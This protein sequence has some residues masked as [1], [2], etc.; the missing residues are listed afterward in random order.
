MYRA[1]VDSPVS[2]L[3]RHTPTDVSQSR[4]VASSEAEPNPERSARAET[5]PRP[6]AAEPAPQAETVLAEGPDVP[7]RRVADLFTALPK[8]ASPDPRLTAELSRRN[9]GGP[10]SAAPPRLRARGAGRPDGIGAP[11]PAE[12][13]AAGKSGAHVEE[14][15]PAAGESAAHAALSLP[16]DGERAADA[17]SS[18]AAAGER[19]PNTAVSEPAAGESPAEAAAIFGRAVPAPA[20]PAL[21]KPRP[22]N[23]V[24]VAP[25]AAHTRAH[26]PEKLA[27]KLRAEGWIVSDIRP[28]DELAT[29]DVVLRYSD[30]GSSHA[31][32][33]KADIDRALGLVRDGDVELQVGGVDPGTLEVW[34]PASSETRKPPSAVRATAPADPP[35]ARARQREGAKPQPS[36]RTARASVQPAPVQPSPSAKPDRRA[37]PPPS[38]GGLPLPPE[39][40]PSSSAPP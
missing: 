35:K 28:V 26:E 32:E 2:V 37:A 4:P 1:W 8:E 30:P 23:V 33:L 24:I 34:L 11:A 15:Q 7:G 25:I 20:T 13:P 38:D 21:P 16:A 14:P 31:L 9:S 29:G 6:D 17:A 3:L 18:A 39:L 36:A 5:P 22:R 12:G 19:R 40:L 10:A 27:R